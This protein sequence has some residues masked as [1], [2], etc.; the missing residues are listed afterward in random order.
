MSTNALRGKGTVPA[1]PSDREIAIGDADHEIFNCPVCQRPLA[2][3]AS[4]CPGCGTRLLLG[5][6]ARKA[7]A[8]IGTGAI[9]GALV[10]GLLVALILLALRP[11]TASGPI[12]VEGPQATPSAG[13]VP[14]K[15]VPNS[16]ANALN[17]TTGL[18]ARM[19]SQLPAL[20]SAIKPSRPNSSEIARILRMINSDAAL[21]T[22][23]VPALAAWTEGR[24]L[25]AELDQYYA[26]VRTAAT[27]ALDITLNNASAYKRNGSRMVALLQ[28]I[29]DLQA[30][31]KVLGD[32]HGIDVGL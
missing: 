30:A 4:R 12:V 5:V 14:P 21:A 20:A 31:A 17:R 10:S 13:V 27:S 24:V 19:A 3:G 18:N 29:A 11:A 28:R 26:D 15:P 8:L 7:T 16:A 32:A 1:R 23:A 25:A 2:T 9:S 22:K 6:Q